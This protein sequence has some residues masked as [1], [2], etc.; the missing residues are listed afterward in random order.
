MNNDLAYDGD[1]IRL[2][3]RGRVGVGE[4]ARRR[5]D[6]I[7]LLTNHAKWVEIEILLP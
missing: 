5:V 3:R 1:Q 2:R 7:P 4:I 6:R